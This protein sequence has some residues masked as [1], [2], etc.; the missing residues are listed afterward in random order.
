MP[1]GRGS[2]GGGTPSGPAGGDLSGSFP[3]PTVNSTSLSAPLPVGQGGTGS[4]T[5]NFVDL[6]NTQVI[7]GAKTFAVP[8]SVPTPVAT[9]DV[10]NKGYADGISAGVVVKTSV[11]AITHGALS[12]TNTYANGTAGVGATLTATANGVLV[13]DGYTVQLN[14]R[15]MVKD[16]AAS[17]ENGIYT[18]TTLGTASVHYV[19]TRATDMDQPTE[20]AGAA[21]FAN[22]GTFNGGSGWAVVGA[23]PYTIGTT[24]ILFTQFTSPGL[25]NAGTG[26]N[27]VGNTM[28]LTT[29]V[30]PA[31]LPA[32]TTGAEGIV[33]LAGDLGG[34]ATAPTVQATTNVENIIRA[35]RL[36]QFT[37][38]TAPVSMG[39]QKITNLANG[40]SPNDGAAFGQIPTTL[41]PTGSA[42][43]DLSGTYPAPTVSKV[44]GI[45][46]TGTPA[47]GQ[48]L[49]ATGSTA[50]A[51]GSQ[52]YT[53]AT[54]V[55]SGAVM[56]QN[57]SN[58]IA[59]SAGLGY[60]VDYVTT[61]TLPTITPVTISAQTITLG[62]S[63]T[64]QVVNW[65]VVNSAG[66]VS[67]LPNPPTPVQR[68]QMIQL[69]VTWS[70][71]STGTLI[72]V[73]SA[74]ITTNQPNTNLYGLAYALG[75]ISLNGNAV[76][77]NG[78][79]L[80]LNKSQGLIHAF[81]FNYATGGANNNNL[82]TAPAE[83]AGNLY[84]VSQLTNSQSAV[85][86]TIDPT[87]WDNGGTLTTISGATS[88]LQR[89]WCL[90]TGTAGNQLVVQYGQA[91]YSN[92]A[93][94]SNAIG[95]EA[96][97]PCPDL[98]QTAVLIGYIAVAAN[99]T[100]LNGASAIFTP[101][102]KFAIP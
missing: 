74:P 21:A 79:N 86:T 8:P 95:H 48:L 49:Q 58:S 99:A 96:F 33:Q 81:A 27:L 47:Y 31:N 68:R 93:N 17:A 70:A 18:V 24:A 30:A 82:V 26:L 63:Q 102:A 1:T 19:L 15:I 69:G 13:V 9:G 61:P 50:A 6:A 75:T 5:Q 91:T 25:L 100:A 54:G 94:A 41:P 77:A 98:Q 78:V 38:P 2:F 92:V 28:S 42:T 60:V 73:M 71:L 72:A 46:V 29:P 90:P 12:P 3:D 62:P 43:G 10:V 97:I 22:N 52:P 36:D 51:W 65:W 101:A 88:T 64:T 59:I 7:T 84:L 83:S 67:S 55:I 87:K 44:N 16:E 23:G 32:A 35:N 11:A 37:A 76:S 56:T 53:S 45:A 14:D 20:I 85:R 40:T 34:T 39:S 66:V 57:S 89:V 4:A 80:S